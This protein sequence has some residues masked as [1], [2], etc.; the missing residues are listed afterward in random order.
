MMKHCVAAAAVAAF[1]GMAMA[2]R[3]TI[4]NPHLAIS[5]PSGSFGARSINTEFNFE[6]PAYTA[7]NIAGQEGW[8][9]SNDGT[10]FA[11]FPVTSAQAVGTQSLLS[12]GGLSPFT[13][14]VGAFG[15]TMD[16]GTGGGTVTWST[17][18]DNQDPFGA[19]QQFVIQSPTDGS[20]VTRVLRDW[21][22]EQILVLAEVAG[23]PTFVNTGV[24]VDFGSWQDWKLD[25]A[26]DAT[27]SLSLDNTEIF[28]GQGFS[29]KLEQVVI[30]ND[31]FAGN[32]MYVDNILVSAIPAPGSVALLGLGG[33]LA[34]RRRRA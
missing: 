7:G 4:Q 29:E 11:D 30:L 13:G 32:D 21:D 1:A 18:F 31:S 12:D 17:Y 14:T 26:P 23:D 27:F 22:T 6:P 19:D 20:V 33:L 16:F 10:T 25:V 5:Q 28:S 9:T 3:P 24:G 15:P 2:D 34:A 8:N